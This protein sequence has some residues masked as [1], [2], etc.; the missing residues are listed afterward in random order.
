MKKKYNLTPDDY[1]VL[2]AEQ[3]FKCGICERHVAELSRPLF[4][5]HDHI[6]GEIRGLLCTRCNSA[7]GAFGDTIEGLEKAIK[8][9]SDR[10][11]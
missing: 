6:T 11:D 9:L 3:N 4:V 1:D 8:Y 5:D 2:L 7:L 10:E